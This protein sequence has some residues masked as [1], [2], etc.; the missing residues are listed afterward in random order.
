MNEKQMEQLRRAYSDRPNFDGRH[1]TGNKKKPGTAI[2]KSQKQRGIDNLSRKDRRSLL[3]LFHEVDNIFGSINMATSAT[4]D[5]HVTKSEFKVKGELRYKAMVF[6]DNGYNT[7]RKRVRKFI[8]Y[9]H[10]QHAVEHLRDIKPHMVG[11]F[12]MSLHEQNLAAKTISN[13]INGIQ[14]LAEGTV[15]DGIKSHAKLVNDHHNQMRKPYN[16]E[17]YRRGKKGGYTP[18]EGQIISKHVH[19]KISPLHGVMVELLYQ[20][21]PRIDELRGIKWRQIDYENKCIWMTDKNQNKNGRP[22]MLPISDEVAEQLQS[23]RDSGLLPKNH[24]EDSAIWGSRMSE[25]DIRNVIKDGCRWGHVGYGG[26]HD[27]R[28]SCYWYQTNRINKEGWSKER[29]AEKIMEHV[30]ADHK[31]NPVEAKKEYARDE[32]GRFIWQRNAQGKAV[33]KILV[34]RLDEHG[35]QVYVLKWTMEELMQLPRQHLVDRYIAEVFGHSRTS[36]TNPYKG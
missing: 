32:T 8:R 4:R 10:A 1:Y 5:D 25:D 24:T 31:L 13:Y 12:I 7:Y 26:A 29:L 27:F 34:P 2:R 28:R 22:R 30:S 23:I 33:R 6:S 9:C 19:G 17:D 16:K 18:R 35:N 36:S 20:S 15:K 14:K 21:G 11:G 3:A